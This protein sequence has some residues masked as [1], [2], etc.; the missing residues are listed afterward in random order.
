MVQYE[1]TG[2][3]PLSMPE[4]EHAWPVYDIF[5]TAD[6]KKIF[7]GVVT[8]GHWW[9]FCE[10]FGLEELS[11]DPTL[12]T[13]TD[14]ILARPKI[15]PLVAER[16]GQETL[17]VMLLIFFLGMFLETIAIILITT[18]IILPAMHQLGIDPIWYGILLMINL[19]LALITPPVGMNLFVIKG[20]TDSPLLEVI[21]GAMPYV[22][23]M[24]I[25][26]LIIF[27][28]PQIALVLPQSAGFGR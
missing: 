12:K 17:A 20:I 19:E 22:L 4:R 14:R 3:K 5:N 23:L 2:V 9:T 26:M 15:L 11:S 6:G 7:I 21:R 1:M 8:E 27:A 18:P 10:E 28:F 16:V 24:I 13:T 25:G